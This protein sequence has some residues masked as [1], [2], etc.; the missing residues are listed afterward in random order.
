MN[1]EL[2]G[3]DAREAVYQRC[4]CVGIA[5]RHGL[6]RRLVLGHARSSGAC[7]RGCLVHIGDGDRVGERGAAAD[8]GRIDGGER[9]AV[10]VFCLVVERD[11][12]LEIER[13][14]AEREARRIGAAEIRGGGGGSVAV[15]HHLS[16]LDCRGGARVLGDPQPFDCECQRRTDGDGGEECQVGGADGDRV[17]RLGERGSRL[18]IEAGLADLKEA[19]VGA[20]NGERVSAEAVVGNDDVGQFCG[21]GA[22]G[23]V[24]KG[25]DGIGKRNGGGGLIAG[26]VDIEREELAGRW[27]AGERGIGRLNRHGVALLGRIA[28]RCPRLEIEHA[29]LELE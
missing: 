14:A 20:G 15:E 17:A 1:R 11:T 3:V 29:R 5:S 28:E 9:D 10:A 23:E 26:A 25:G 18:E 22:G 13:V 21:G 19:A 4:A 16:H 24:A 12:R 6:D 8:H 2:R 7:H 27:R